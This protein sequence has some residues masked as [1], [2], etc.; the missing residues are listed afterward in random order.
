MFSKASNLILLIRYQNIYE[1][2]LISNINW[3]KIAFQKDDIE[4]SIKSKSILRK[5]IT[6]KQYNIESDI[7]KKVQ[8]VPY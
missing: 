7:D 8:N 4:S 2:F 5:I 3:L 6:D 1:S